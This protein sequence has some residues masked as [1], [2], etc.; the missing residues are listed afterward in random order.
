MFT[1]LTTDTIVLPN[2]LYKNIERS[3]D[4]NHVINNAVIDRSIG[5]C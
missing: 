4:Q 5:W 3:C 2:A 1:F